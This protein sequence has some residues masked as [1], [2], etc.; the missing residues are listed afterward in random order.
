MSH[1]AHEDDLATKDT[2]TTKIEGRSPAAEGGVA[3]D[4]RATTSRGR[5]YGGLWLPF[6]PPRW[7]PASLAAGRTALVTFVCFVAKSV[8]AISAFGAFL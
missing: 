1:E 6:R 7:R 5:Y 8:S 4:E 3:A 2:K